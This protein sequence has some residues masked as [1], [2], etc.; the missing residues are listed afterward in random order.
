MK[1][2]SIIYYLARPQLIIQRLQ[3]AIYV[4]RHPDE[5]WLSPDSVRF[6]DKNLNKKMTLFEWGSGRSTLWF[7][8][9][10]KD[11][12]S[13]EYH[14]G[15]AQ[16]VE[17]MLQDK[18]VR[19]VELCY[20]PLEHPIKEPTPKHYDP[21]PKY[22]SKIFSYPKKHFDVV[23][24]DGHYRLTCA[25]QCLD[26]VKEGGILVID[27]SNRVSLEEWAIPK[28]WPI[29]HESENVVTRTTVWKKQSL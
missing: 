4:R 19:N 28:S 2:S 12:V 26:S 21:I 20:I 11:V 8:K 16:K 6:L 3:Y 23:L 10:V 25:D 27:N 24:I 13:I 14:S 29:V 22:V 15:W 5:P 17:K 18:S 7:A 1:L 9:R